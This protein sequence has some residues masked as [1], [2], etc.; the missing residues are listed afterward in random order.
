Q[1]AI[2]AKY[3]GIPYFVTGLPDAAH[4]GIDTV[5]IEERDSKLVLEA[6]GVKNTLDGVKGYY[7][8]FDITP[9]HLVSGVVTDKGIYSPYDLHRYFDSTVKQFY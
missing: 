9:P 1:I 7:P 3:H 2:A 4:P 6:R 5:K 8:S